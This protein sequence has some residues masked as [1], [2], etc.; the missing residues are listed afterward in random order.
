[1]VP[2]PAWRAASA[3]YS[4]RMHHLPAGEPETSAHAK[5]PVDRMVESPHAPRPHPYFGKAFSGRILGYTWWKSGWSTVFPDGTACELF[6]F[7][8]PEL[9][10]G[11]DSWADVASHLK[12]PTDAPVAFDLAHWEAGTWPASGRAPGGTYVWPTGLVYDHVESIWV[13]DDHGRPAYVAAGCRQP[14]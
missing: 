5:R 13:V 10:E 1:M 2:T 7:V 14:R 6:T 3:E 4:Q 11:A 8:P 9:W 12:F